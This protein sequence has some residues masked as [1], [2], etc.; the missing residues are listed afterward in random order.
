MLVFWGAAKAE[1]I[2]KT[3]GRTLTRMRP[4]IP[5]HRFEPFHQ[6]QM[7]GSAEGDIVLVC[8]SA[9]LDLM[10]ELKLVKKSQSMTSLRIKPFRLPGQP[11]QYLA[12]YD[13]N[14]IAS[15]PEKATLI[16]WDVRLAA[17]VMTTG[18]V[19]PIIGNYQWVNSFAPLIARIEA[20]YAKTGQSV[21]V[22]CDTET[23]G[24]VPYYEDKT[25]VSIGF[26]DRAGHADCL[27][28][29][30]FPDP[31]EIDQSV[32]L[33]GQLEWLLNSP[34]VKLRGA[35]F[36][37]DL[38]WFAERLGLLC[39]NLKFDTTMVGS[40][41]NENRQNSL[42][43]HAKVYTDIGGYDD[44][45]NSEVD[46]SHMELVPP[47]KLLPYQGGDIDATFQVADKLR[48][49]LLEDP[50]LARF[51][52]NILHPASRAFEKIERRGV[53]VDTTEFG[54]V[55]HDLNTA[56][57]DS[58]LQ[59]M[60]L[61]P[62]K[63]RYKYKEKIRLQEDSEKSPLTSKIL[64]D[65]FFTNQGLNLKPL[66]FTEKTN[67]PSTAKAHLRMFAHIPEAQL[68]CDALE[69]LNGASK[70]K[71]TFVIGFLKHLRP[72][73][74][75]HPSYM[76]HHGDFNNDVSNESGSVTGRL[77]A[78]EPAIQ[79]LPNKTLWAKRLRA[80]FIAPPG[81][82]ILKLDYSQGELRIAACLSN[83]T[84]ML[85]AYAQ[86]LDLHAVTGA[87]LGGYDFAAFMELKQSN[88]ALYSLVRDK[89]KPA[90][91]GLLYGMGPEGFQIYAWATYGLQL[92]LEE[93]TGMRDAFFE[94]YPKLLDYHKTMRE[95]VRNYKFVRSPLGRVRHLD[96]ASS[97]DRAVKAKAERQAINSPTQ[98]TLTDMLI[99]SVAD[100]ERELPEADFATVCTIHDAVMAY[101]NENKVVEMATQAA[102]IMAN[103]PF[104]KFDWQPQLTFPADAEYGMTL[105]SL[106]KIKLA[107]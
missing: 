82:R 32:D 84:T 11:G 57:R 97:W 20:K 21:D 43:L 12:T 49:E 17:R 75:L 23:M 90:N 76:L 29:G 81:K 67:A 106:N 18:S 105:A 89:A 46:K 107:A 63:L 52:V 19:L 24:L 100:F 88:P 37:Y 54:K 47:D 45:F 55:E 85:S 26:T 104:D 98:A 74:K 73:G 96:T 80:C 2:K 86:D 92:T 22:A 16:D 40:L 94:L 28:L 69:T 101:V 103:R 15:D 79:T 25:F 41:L 13:P 33:L 14:V 102:S 5:P 70:T 64:F 35:N 68:M 53:C 61:L 87:K 1:Q 8:G 78:K 65:Y 51:Y 30:P 77:A 44:T 4:G 31:V 50:E 42:N 66:M 95:V 3:I 60:D 83:E 71:S 62:M 6:G 72:D 48:E 99:W 91:F 58:T 10:K 38:T 27:Y 9:P 36:K 93:A 56:I 7:V 39:T 34:K 59:A